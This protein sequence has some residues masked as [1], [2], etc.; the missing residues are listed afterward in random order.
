MKNN[1]LLNLSTIFYYKKEQL[2]L[3]LS[4]HWVQ[5]S[6]VLFFGYT[7]L[8]KDINIQLTLRSP[9]APV[10]QKEKEND[11]VELAFSTKVA[12]FGNKK[13]NPAKRIQQQ[14]YIDRFLNIAKKENKKFGIPTSIKLAQ[15]LL[16][17]NAGTSPLSIKHNNHFGIKCFSK[18][19]KK[20]HCSNL[21]DDTHKDFFI[22]YKNA[23]ESYRAHSLFLT[24]SARYQKL[25]ELDPKDYK[26][27][28]YGLQQAGYATDKSYAKKLIDII[29]S[30]HLDQYD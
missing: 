22:N 29:E 24:K 8:Q 13:V 9:I 6:I 26:A 15:G 4:K 17:S 18:S 12:N 7:I 5:L 30:F 16:E 10:E 2:Y 25:F 14:A 21:D 27:W 1:L 23:W 3:W 28:A 20:T 19:C 11:L